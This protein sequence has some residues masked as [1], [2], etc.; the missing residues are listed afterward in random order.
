MILKHEVKMYLI[1]I[2]IDKACFYV[3]SCVKALLVTSNFSVTCLSK[4]MINFF[5]ATSGL[6]R[7]IILKRSYKYTSDLQTCELSS[8]VKSDVT[9]LLRVVTPCGLSGR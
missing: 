5:I 1:L 2:P 9:I 6:C 8:S 3:L 4:I 7:M